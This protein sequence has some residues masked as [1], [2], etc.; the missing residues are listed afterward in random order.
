MQ[1]DEARAKVLPALGGLGV[2][3]PVVVEPGLGG[4]VPG[5]AAQAPV[6]GALLHGGLEDVVGGARAGVERGQERLVGELV[7]SVHGGPAL[8]CAVG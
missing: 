2:A 7:V 4:R 6:V 5:A 3:D 8:L 1:L